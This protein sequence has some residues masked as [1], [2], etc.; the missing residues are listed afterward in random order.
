MCQFSAADSFSVSCRKNSI[1]IM[2]VE[3]FMAP[4]QVYLYACSGVK[5]KQGRIAQQSVLSVYCWMQ[6]LSLYYPLD[7]SKYENSPFLLLM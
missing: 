6:Q 2:S 4:P 1:C 3:H 7:L 5:S